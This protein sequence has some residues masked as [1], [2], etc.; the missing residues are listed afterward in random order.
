MPMA[1]PESL[2]LAFMGTPDFA[3]PT[4][5]ALVTAGHQVCAVYCQPPRPAGRGQKPRL[6]PVQARAEALGLNVYYPT[7]L[8]AAAAQADF[9]QLDLDAAVV[10]A[11]GLILPPEILAAPRLGCL[12]VHAS[13]LPRWRG[14]A[15]IQRAIQAGDQETGVTLM[16]MD[17]GLDTGPT[18]CRQ[19][20][21][22]DAQVTGGRLHDR[23]AALGGKMIADGLKDWAAG[24]LVAR[25]QADDNITYA[26]KLSRAE[27]Q[28]DWRQPA[29]FLARTIRAFDPWPGCWFLDRGSRLALKAAMVV[30]G[31]NSAAAPGQVLD[32]ELTIQCGQDALRLSV[33]QRPGKAALPTA[34]FLRGYDLPVGTLLG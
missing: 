22:L 25:P 11:Y 6:S 2:R 18:L 8:K 3:V 23:L 12:N 34:D 29:D 20:V 13:L 17:A 30:R 1:H 24:R 28:I 21:P 15:P 32:T 9:A 27:G 7:S 14:A 31:G 10:V 4:L 5:D 19:V 33:L 16:V 26:H